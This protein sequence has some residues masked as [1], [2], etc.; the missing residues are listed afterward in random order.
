[1]IRGVI[2][3]H[4]LQRI[5]GK[6]IAAVIVDGFDRGES[7]KPYALAVA[8]S[9]GKESYPSPRSVEKKSFDRMVVESTKCI[10]NIKSMVAR[11]EGHW[12]VSILYI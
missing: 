3:S 12:K 6:S 11:V 4:P 5:P 2:A 8:H 7:E 1:M 10:R 9:R